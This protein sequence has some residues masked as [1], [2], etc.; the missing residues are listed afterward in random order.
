MN[1]PE[2]AWWNGYR[3]TQVYED[4]YYVWRGEWSDPAYVVASN[5]ANVPV[6]GEHIDGE[7]VNYE[8]VWGWFEE[9]YEPTRQEIA[10]AVYDSIAA[11][12]E[13]Q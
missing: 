3:A 13:V 12:E 5:V 11:M 10:Q 1:Y 8:D 6:F 9:G 2:K 4:V 7:E